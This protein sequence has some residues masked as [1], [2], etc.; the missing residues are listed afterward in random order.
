MLLNGDYKV[1]PNEINVLE[2]LMFLFEQS[3]S[4]QLYLKFLYNIDSIH[5]IVY[6]PSCTLST[7]TGGCYF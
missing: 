1:Y 5:C 7:I 6:C 2:L 4:K 3:L